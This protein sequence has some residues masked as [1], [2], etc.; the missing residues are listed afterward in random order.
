[1]SKIGVLPV[2]AVGPATAKAAREA[3]L[4]LATIGTSGIEHL[5]RSIDPNLRLLH[6]CGEHRTEAE[7]PQQVIAIPVYRS[8]ALSPIP[9]F[10]QI[11]GQT[12]ALHSRR[13]ASRLAELVDR[14]GLARSTIRVAAMSEPVREAAGEGW[15]LSKAIERPDSARLLA[16]AAS[17]CDKPSPK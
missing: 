8:A 3:G 12:V 13:A 1:L 10:E 5:L 6:L 11:E 15:E 2:H 16:L 7:G 14:H 9:D 4:S 17:L